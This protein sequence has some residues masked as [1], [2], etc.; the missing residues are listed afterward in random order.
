MRVKKESQLDTS[1]ESYAWQKEAVENL[2]SGNEVRTQEQVEQ[3]DA[4][5]QQA[6]EEYSNS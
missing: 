1:A 5:Y 3:A 4:Q 2:I 6:M